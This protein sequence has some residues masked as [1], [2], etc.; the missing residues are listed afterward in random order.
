[1]Y[2]TKILKLYKRNSEENKFH[3]NYFLLTEKILSCSYEE[4]T[5]KNLAIL[6]T[7]DET[8]KDLVIVSFFRYNFSCP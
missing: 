1:M 6:S 8:F 7:L 2:I 3:D 5:N 4:S